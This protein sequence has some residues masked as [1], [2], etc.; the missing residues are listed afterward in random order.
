MTGILTAF[1]VFLILGV[2]IGLLL[3]VASKVFHVERDERI[4]KIIEALP[5]ANCGGCGYAGCSALAESVVKGEAKCNACT[6]GGDEVAKKVAAVMGVEAESAERNSLVYR[7]IPPT[8]P[9]PW[10]LSAS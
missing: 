5:G 9:T 2:V 1:L 4:D 8:T 3:A 6:V 7:T 10:I